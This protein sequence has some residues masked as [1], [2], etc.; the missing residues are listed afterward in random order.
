M[1]WEFDVVERLGLLWSIAGVFTFLAVVTSTY[2]IYKHMRHYTQPHL[3]RY[4]VR[5]LLMVPIYAVDSF[6]SFRFISLSL[7][8]DLIRD[9]YEAYV[10][11]NFFTL[12]V[13]FVNTYDYETVRR[14]AALAAARAEREESGAEAPAPQEGLEWDEWDEWL[15]EQEGNRG[16][17]AP[18]VVSVSEDAVV[19]LLERKPLASHPFPTC[20]LPQFQPGKRFLTVAKRCVFQ[21]VVIKPLLALIAIFL[22]LKGWYGDGEWR[23]DSGYLY[24]LIV[25]NISVTLA[26]YFLVLFFHV[27]KDELKPF[28]PV[29]KVC[30]QLRATLSSHTGSRSLYFSPPPSTSC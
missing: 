19:A 1:A 12:L 17:G 8:F 14:K 10:I 9:A 24:L 11:Y 29:P 5:I 15:D 27:M 25:D 7:Y 3:Q 4:I 6:L 21:F 30:V 28:N 20:F 18:V 22:E 23:L 13:A 26:M 16:S 2:L